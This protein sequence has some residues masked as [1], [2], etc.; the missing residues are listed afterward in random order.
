MRPALDLRLYFVVG[1]QDCAGR[2]LEAVVAAALRGGVTCVQLRDKTA[3]LGPREVLR[4]AERC[5]AQ[6]VPLLVNDSLDLAAYAQGLH[7]GQDDSHPKLARARLGDAALIGLSVGSLAER[8]RFDASRHDLDYDDLDYIG[9]GPAATTR[10][11]ADAGAALGLDGLAR[12]TRRFALPWVAIGGITAAQIA[13]IMALGA[14]GGAVISAIAAAPDP[15]RAA[16]TLRAEIEK[17]G[18]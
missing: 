16:E 17:S 14:A 18:N 2:D 11:K 8:Q 10:S 6:A 1:P 5:R 4:I 9:V 13:D 12:V 3:T 7:L 15:C